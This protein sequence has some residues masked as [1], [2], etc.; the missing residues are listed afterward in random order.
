MVVGI[1]FRWCALF[2]IS[3]IRRVRTFQGGRSDMA[4]GIGAAAECTRSVDV[5]AA[6]ESPDCG[7]T[8]PGA[9]SWSKRE[10]SARRARGHGQLASSA[11]WE[12]LSAVAHGSCGHSLI[13]HAGDRF[14]EGLGRIVEPEPVAMFVGRR[15]RPEREVHV[16]VVLPIAF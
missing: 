4:Y 16:G 5:P 10:G 1:Y 2:G 9:E 8:I 7:R 13:L 15:E 12:S 11:A 6:G 14:V 3:L